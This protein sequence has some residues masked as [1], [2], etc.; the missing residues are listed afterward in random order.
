MLGLYV[1]DHPLLGA[2]AA[3]AR[4]AEASLTDL[5]DMEDG[6]PTAVVAAG[7]V[8]AQPG[9]RVE[10]DRGGTPLDGVHRGG[11]TGRAGTDHGDGGGSIVIL[12][13]RNAKG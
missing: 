9:R 10:Q 12:R 3:L 1:S 11:Q 2:E 8:A 13:V 4:R 6:A 5:L 7:G